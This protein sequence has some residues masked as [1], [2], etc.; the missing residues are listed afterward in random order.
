MAVINL[1]FQSKSQTSVTH[2]TMANGCIFH[3]RYIDGT[4]EFRAEHFT[5]KSNNAREISKL[6]S[7]LSFLIEKIFTDMTNKGEIIWPN[8]S[9]LGF[10]RYTLRINKSI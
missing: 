4:T 10:I 2:A 3:L 7:G 1:F 5:F 9:W 8:K 6:R